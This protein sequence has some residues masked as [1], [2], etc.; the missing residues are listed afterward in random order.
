M[1]LEG[2][3]A[4]IDD[5]DAPA[6][7]QHLA[8]T[9]P[10]AAPDLVDGD[11]V[12]LLIRAIFVSDPTRADASLAVVDALLQGG[13]SPNMADEDGQTPLHVCAS[14]LKREPD[15]AVGATEALLDALLQHPDT[16]RDAEGRT[17]LAVVVGQGRTISPAG[18]EEA[19]EAAMATA[20]RLFVERGCS[21][22]A[23]TGRQ[24]SHGDEAVGA[25]GTA[26][27]DEART[28][29][30]HEAAEWAPPAVVAALLLAPDIEDAMA[31]A[32]AA[33]DGPLQVTECD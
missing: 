17:P 10:A 19:G 28:T 1:D 6:V 26:A 20:A 15:F 24:P 8:A 9:A 14:K 29:L 12:P 22:L 18:G 25:A 30:L 2:L 32:D 33:G 27:S 13:L 21:L 4:A 11:G 5:L 16:L 23:A 3:E 31:T 7:S